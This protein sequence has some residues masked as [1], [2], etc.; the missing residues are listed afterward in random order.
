MPHTIVAVKLAS[1]ISLLGARCTQS[2]SLIA[3]SVRI[4]HVD[5]INLRC[6]SGIH[7]CSWNFLDK[8][9]AKKECYTLNC[10]SKRRIEEG[11]S[12]CFITIA[13]RCTDIM[14]NGDCIFRV[15]GN[16]IVSRFLVN[17]WSLIYR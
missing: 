12:T 7:Y 8:K 13:S 4:D 14:G 10:W 17:T 3:R 16:A 9:L 15:G 11:L 1:V 6:R 5:V 2:K